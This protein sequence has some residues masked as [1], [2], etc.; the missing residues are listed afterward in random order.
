MELKEGD[1]IKIFPDTNIY[2]YMN[3]IKDSGFR[4]H[5]EGNHIVVDKA[6]EWHRTSVYGKQIKEARKA[7][8]W[9]RAELAEKCGV[10]ESTVFDWELGTRR[11]QEWQKVQKILWG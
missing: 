8:G 5:L 4:C 9:T 1:R 2:T 7:K 3:F 11:P 10:R 6:Y